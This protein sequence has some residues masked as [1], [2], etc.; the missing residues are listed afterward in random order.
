[1][2]LLT[3]SLGAYLLATP[4]CDWLRLPCLVAGYWRA[5]PLHSAP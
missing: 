5:G 2:L 1:M 4:T 3:Y